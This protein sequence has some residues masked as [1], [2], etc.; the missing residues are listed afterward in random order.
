[1]GALL[2]RV[3]VATSATGSAATP[4]TLGAAETGF[5]TMSAAGAVDGTL[6]TYVIEDGN[7]WEIQ[8]QAY[9][10]SGPSLARGTPIASSNSGSRITLTGSAKIFISP[11]A[12]DVGSPCIIDVF[13]SSGTWTK[14]QGL[15]S[16]RVVAFAGGNGGAAGRRG[17]AASVRGGGSGGPGGSAA[18]A[19]ILNADLSSTVTVTVGAGGTGT[20]AVTTDDT[21]GAFGGAGGITSFGNY[22]ESGAVSATAPGSTANAGPTSSCDWMY[23]GGNGGLGQSVGGQVGGQGGIGAGLAA[24]GGG[25]GAGISSG[26]TITG[27]AGGGGGAMI[28]RGNNGGFISANGAGIA[29]TSGTP[30]GGDA[31]ASPS[32]IIG[33]AGGGGGYP[34]LAGAGGSGGNGAAP[35]GGG[36][37]GAGSANG[38]NSGKGGN[39]AA[40]R[41]VV[42]NYF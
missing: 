33:G 29:G 40:G 14:R 1:M 35:G 36:G 10:A 23:R 25:G 26:N 18:V 3:K 24:G 21:T 27:A 4:I 2:N 34:V 15:K 30:N 7:D 32:L 8:S 37:G 22:L 42:F 20:G 31:T 41:V 5:Q 6:Y 17:A 38:N 16:I 11:C 13:D 9:T 19:D 28:R 39:G 12:D